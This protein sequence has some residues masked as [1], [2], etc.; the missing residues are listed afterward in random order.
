[1]FLVQADERWV[2]IVWPDGKTAEALIE[3][4]HAQRIQN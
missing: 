3:S 1:M 4:N 2:K